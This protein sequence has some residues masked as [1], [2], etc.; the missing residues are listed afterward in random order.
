MKKPVYNVAH[1][2]PWPS[3][4]G[5]ELATL[6]IAQ[7]VESAGFRSVAFC[8]AEG[9]PVRELFRAAGFETA[10]Y[11]GVP[12]SYLHPRAFLRNSLALAREF[13]RRRVR[14]VHCSDVLAGFYAA[15]AGRLAGVPVLCHVRCV[16]ADVP[17][18]ERGFLAPVSKFAFVSRDAWAKFG[19]KVSARRGRVVYDGVEV[20]AQARDEEGR[21]ALAE[22]ARAG[23]RREFGLE[24]GVKTVGMVAR[25]APAK[26]FETL[27]KAAARVLEAEPGVRFMVVGDN[28]REAPYRAHYQE[29]KAM[30]DARGLTDSFIFTGFREDVA[31]FVSAFDVFVLSTH[32]EGLPL[33]VLEAMA[34]GVPV[35]ATGVGG[36]PEVIRHGE[37]GL[38]HAH[39]DDAAL[40][41]HLRSLL[42]DEVG[43]AELGEAG[44]RHVES[45][46]GLERFAREMTNLYRELLGDKAHARREREGRAAAD[47]LKQL[48]GN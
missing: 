45:E 12:P 7:A 24:A 43:A 31:R 13:R 37:N 28:S 26:D 11:E 41:E 5:T 32:G 48:G 10:R 42:S 19:H 46:F 33:V 21:I 30:L 2:L 9:Q 6:R 29:V 3:V 27:A 1:V 40:A 39:G 20:S 35:A 22:E 16:F 44:R 18:R 38:L 14:L 4:G 8:L 47:A 25:V 36:I 17:R 23:V 34:R 15:L